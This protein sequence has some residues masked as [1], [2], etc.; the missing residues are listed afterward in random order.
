[1]T[2]Q[3][4]DWKRMAF[5]NNKV[6][7]AVDEQGQ[8][9]KKN[10][11]VL[12]KYQLDHDYE[13]RV[14]EANITSVNHLKKKSPKRPKKG[15][16]GPSSPGQENQSLE[17]IKADLPP[18]T[19]LVFTDGASSGNPGPSGIG[20]HL[21]YKENEKSISRYIGP[22]TNNIAE[23]KAI[24]AGLLEIKNRQ[25]PVRVFTD[26]GY[27]FGVL[28]KGWQ[29]RKNKELIES[30]RK[31]MAGFKDLRLIKVKGHAG[32]IENE[33]A[34]QLATAAIKK[35]RAIDAG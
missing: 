18:E 24:Q 2:Q 3:P 21:I 34:D 13:Y 28:V 29:A 31:T 26:S 1:M 23:L 12:I 10:G 19:I 7:M 11:K 22:A 16:A 27:A 14:H 25:M 17:A 8:P 15:G 20:V 5:K 4:A 35:A 30:I 32:Q 6:W 9:L 33:K